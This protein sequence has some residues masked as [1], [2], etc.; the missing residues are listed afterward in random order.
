MEIKNVQTDKTTVQVGEQITIVFE[1]W[2]PVDY[3][4][5]YPYDYPISAERK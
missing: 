4:Y 3:P 1:V 5:D 2:Y